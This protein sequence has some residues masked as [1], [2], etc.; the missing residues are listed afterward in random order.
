[1]IDKNLV[2]SQE[3]I[4]QSTA[5]IVCTYLGQNKLSVQEVPVLIAA[6][7]DA[8]Q[9]AARSKYQAV[10][11]QPKK[12]KPHAA[13]HKSVGRDHIICLE[14]GLKFRSMKRHLMSQ[15]QMT[16]AEYRRKW[17]LPPEYPMVAPSYAEM[18][19]KLARG[20]RWGE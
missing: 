6:V 7:C 19:A 20:W 14:D 18:R 9:I 13:P 16:P 3:A 8:L 1:M 4:I 5:D 10:E 12:T 17:N 15:H 11:V 2:A